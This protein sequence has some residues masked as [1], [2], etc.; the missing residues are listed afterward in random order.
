MTSFTI[1]DIREI[2]SFIGLNLDGFA[3]SGLKLETDDDLLAWRDWLS[4]QPESQKVVGT[5]DPVGNLIPGDAGFWV[6]IEEHG[7]I[8]ACHAFR[9]IETRSLLQDIMTWR[10]I[11]NRR[12]LVHIDPIPLRPNVP[13]LSG[14]I[15]FG[16]GAYVHPGQRG[17]RLYRP[18]SRITWALGLRHYDLDWYAAFYRQTPQLRAASRSALFRNLGPLMNDIWPPHGVPLELNLAFMS[19]QEMLTTIR[20]HTGS[21]TDD[22]SAVYRIA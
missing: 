4:S 17:R 12:P 13:D 15:G 3:E 9:M 6:R 8:V 21:G 18:M 22:G 10:I 2:Q 7:K 16:G 19:R 20:S 5:Q 11:S 14:R 1:D